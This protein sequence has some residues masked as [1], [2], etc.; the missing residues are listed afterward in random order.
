MNYMNLLE[1]TWSRAFFS[2][3]RVYPKIVLYS[4]FFIQKAVATVAGLQQGYVICPSDNRFVLLFTF[5]KKN[6]KR[7]IIVFF[8]SCAAVKFYAELFNYIDI[9]VLELHVG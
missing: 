5:L 7:K 1:L 3:T 6:L 2:L 9:P 4:D 8:S